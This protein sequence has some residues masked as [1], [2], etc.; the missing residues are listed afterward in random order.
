MSKQPTGLHQYRGRWQVDKFVNGRRLRRSFQDRDAAERWL[1]QQ[2]SAVLDGD[3]SIY[4]QNMIFAECANRYLR[5][6]TEAG[7]VSAGT[8]GYVLK[9]LLQRIPVGISIDEFSSETLADWR[10]HVTRHG[11]PASSKTIR[12]GISLAQSILKQAHEVWRIP[13]TGYP[14]LERM[15]RLD[16]PKLENQRK[17]R[18]IS[19]SEQDRLMEFLPEHLREMTLFA[20]HTGA[21]EAVICHLLWRWIHE[22]EPGGMRYVVVPQ[23]YTKGRRETRVLFLNSEA[24]KVIDRQRGRHPQRVFTWRRVAKDKEPASMRRSGY[25]P[26][27]HMNNSAWQ[28]AREQAGLPEVRVHDLRH[29]FATRLAAAGVDKSTINQLLWHAPTTI[30]D[31]YTDASVDRLQQAVE[32]L[33]V[34]PQAGDLSL[35]ALLHRVQRQQ[36][37]QGVRSSGSA[38]GHAGR[39]GR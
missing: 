11:K 18:P 1:R 8:A 29:T 10:K 26:L 12:E 36:H 31:H 7:K 34:R 37:A 32:Q 23:D 27:E 19:W 13:G 2:T 9:S 14:L 38:Q 21:R 6:M 25:A 33:T 30:T 4:R 17:P 15:P 20:V 5:E 24:I 28:R 35:R 39:T 16:L 3:P 22:L